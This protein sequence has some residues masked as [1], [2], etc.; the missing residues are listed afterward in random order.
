VRAKAL[1]EKAIETSDD[2][3]AFDGLGQA[4][5]WLRDLEG[6]LPQRERAYLLFR[7]AGNY[8][9]AAYIAEE[10]FARRMETVL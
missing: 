1:F 8:R 9:R 3:V 10:D 4:L 7:E 5:L 2:P 6:C